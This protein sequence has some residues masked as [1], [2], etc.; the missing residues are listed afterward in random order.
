MLEG[1]SLVFLFEFSIHSNLIMRKCFCEFVFD[2][3]KLSKHKLHK[4]QRNFGKLPT[5]LA[6]LKLF[7]LFLLW[8]KNMLFSVVRITD[9]FL[10]TGLS[11]AKLFILKTVTSSVYLINSILMATH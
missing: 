4:P 3:K 7:I 5:F 1:V 6:L 8:G 10:S 9:L 2:M 11:G